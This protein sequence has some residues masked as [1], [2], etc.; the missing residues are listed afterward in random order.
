MG[1]LHS[2]YRLDDHPILVDQRLL[3][4][5]LFRVYDEDRT[6]RTRPT[7][8]DRA[9]RRSDVFYPL[10]TAV[11]IRAAGKRR[12]FRDDVRCAG[13]FRQA[14]QPGALVAHRAAGHPLVLVRKAHCTG[15]A[16]AASDLVCRHW[17]IGAHDLSTSLRRHSDWSSPRRVVCVVVAGPATESGRDAGAVA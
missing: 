15:G 16:L 6:R 7:L 4:T 10:S 8:A 14:V 17:F 2:V 5:V 3:C 9:T 13:E 12:H 11:Y 1:T